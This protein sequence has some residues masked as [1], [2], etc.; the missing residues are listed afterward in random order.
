MIYK[1]HTVRVMQNEFRTYNDLKKELKIIQDTHQRAL[2]NYQDK[3][4]RCKL[5]REKIKSPGKGDGLGGYIEPSDA[6]INRLLEEEKEWY[7]KLIKYRQTIGAAREMEIQQ[8]QNRI[9]TVDF[10]FSLLEGDEKDMVYDH[11]FT[12]MSQK[13]KM[14]KWGYDNTGNYTRKIK[15]ILEDI[16]EIV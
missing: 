13:K 5:N 1:I 3:I 15:Y 10:Y 2:D 8:L 4:E 14:E 6:K 16:I 9:D 12:N 7:I 11:Y